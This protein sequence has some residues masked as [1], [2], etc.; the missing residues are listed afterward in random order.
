MCVCVCLSV[1][2]CACPC[3]YVSA[4]CG[5]ICGCER[6]VVVVG[7]GVYNFVCLYKFVCHLHLS[8]FS[9]NRNVAR[10]I[11]NLSDVHL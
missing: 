2:L 3:M 9:S 6:V 7:G 10:V 8:H 5:C 11:N 1:C 4:V